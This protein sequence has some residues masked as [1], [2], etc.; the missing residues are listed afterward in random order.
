MKSDELSAQSAAE[1]KTNNV[2]QAENYFTA[3]AG[4]DKTNPNAGVHGGNAA[5]AA[6]Q[7]AL[8]FNM[9]PTVLAL[10]ADAFQ[11]MPEGTSHFAL[12]RRHAAQSA[13]THSRSRRL[14]LPSQ[15]Q[16]AQLGYFGNDRTVAEWRSTTEQ[17][18]NQ[19]I[20]AVASQIDKIKSL[21]GVDAETKIKMLEGLGARMEQG[22]VQIK[23][24]I[25]AADK[26]S[27]GQYGWVTKGTPMFDINEV[28]YGPNGLKNGI[29][30]AT[31]NLQEDMN[32]LSEELAA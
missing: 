28:Y 17:T 12:C 32:T 18:I 9:S 16:G 22:F 20:S 8:E 21:Q 6:K 24:S 25:Q 31:K 7:L 13:V 3:Y 19:H 27:T 29:D 5:M 30:A 26:Y 15:M 23:N 14:S 2:A 4:K 11:T 10:M 1:Y